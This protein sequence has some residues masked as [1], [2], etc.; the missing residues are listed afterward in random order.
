MDLP[1]FRKRFA[2]DKDGLTSLSIVQWQFSGKD[3]LLN[4]QL[5]IGVTANIFGLGGKIYFQISL[6]FLLMAL[7][8]HGKVFKGYLEIAIS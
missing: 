7:L 6:F 2:K 4:Q 5:A 1:I 8:L 3:L